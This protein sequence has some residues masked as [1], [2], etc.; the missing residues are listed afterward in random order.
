MEYSNE[1]VL[2]N[3]DH[4][5]VEIKSWNVD[6]SYQKTLKPT[7]TCR[8]ALATN[9]RPKLSGQDRLTEVGQS[10]DSGFVL[11]MCWL[12]T[13]TTREHACDRQRIP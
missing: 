1:P 4:G 2:S 5:G 11:P 8:S 9:C 6:S 10:V 12:L 7:F 3:C 13:D